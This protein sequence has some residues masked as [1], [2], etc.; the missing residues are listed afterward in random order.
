M[1]DGVLSSQDFDLRLGSRVVWVMVG[2]VSKQTTYFPLDN[3]WLILKLKF[4]LN[5]SNMLKNITMTLPMGSVN[6]WHG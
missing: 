1:Y 4:S 6:Q 5:L 2:R 3:I